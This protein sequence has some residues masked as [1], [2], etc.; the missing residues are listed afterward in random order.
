MEKTTI[1]LLDVLQQAATLLLDR[2]HQ[3]WPGVTA[4]L[5][6]EL[7]LVSWAA[8]TSVY[9]WRHPPL[10]MMKIAGKFG[11]IF[12][13]HV[14][15]ST[16]V[17]WLVLSKA[18][19]TGEAATPTPALDMALA[20]G[21][22]WFVASILKTSNMGTS[23]KAY[24]ILFLVG[25]L[26]LF[27]TN[28]LGAVIDMLQG[29]KLSFGAFSLSLWVL[30]KAIG[31]FVGLV[32]ATTGTT[33]E[34]RRYMGRH[35]KFTPTMREV[36]V[37]VSNISGIVVAAIVSLNMLGLDFTALTVFS[38]ALGIGLGFGLR[39]VF[40]NLVS[41]FILLMDKSVKPGDVI[42]VDGNHGVITEMNA[43]CVV[44]QTGDGIELMLPNER[45]VSSNVMNWSYNSKNVRQKLD[46]VIAYTADLELAQKLMLTLAREHKRV[47]RSPAPVVFIKDFV[48]NGINLELRY[49][50][51]DPEEGL[52]DVKS[53]LLMGIWKQFKQHKIQIPLP[54]M[55]LHR[56]GYEPFATTPANGTFGTNNDEEK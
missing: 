47:L 19:F 3:L 50:L 35:R 2:L 34:L 48:H 28:H 39:T 55:V 52:A 25:V 9:A 17:F 7:L 40:S 32:W 41:G 11:S 8:L 21:M 45:L 33:R 43:R 13:A 20:V 54:Q 24:I 1:N 49:W 10:K 31:V 12:G 38:G 42:A 22:L 27:I 30:F 18:L 44:L 26:G 46:V 6:L 23:Q 37:K 14:V 53:D 29:A 56:G 15:P 51:K 4:T 16:F 5:W 36:I